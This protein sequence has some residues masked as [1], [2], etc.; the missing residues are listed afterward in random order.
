MS[1]PAD[2][3]D[4]AA[5]MSNLYVEAALSRHKPLY[6][7]NEPSLSECKE[8]DGEIPEARQKVLPGVTLCV[9]CAEHKGGRR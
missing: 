9:A 5:D 8:C 6:N 1:K 7:S 4:F 3:L 2:V